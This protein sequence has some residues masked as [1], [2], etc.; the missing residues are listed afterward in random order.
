MRIVLLHG[1]LMSPGIWSAVRRAL[2]PALEVVAPSQP[3]HGTEPPLTDNSMAGW[4]DWL[5]TRADTDKPLLLV[6]HSMGGML[7]M[8]MLAHRPE[9]VAGVVVVAATATAWSAEQ[10]AGWQS[11]LA[12]AAR[13][14]APQMAQALGGV[15]FGARY[16]HDH[17]EEVG[18]W[19][20]LWRDEQDLAAAGRLG[21]VIAQREELTARPLRR[22]PAAMLRGAEDPAITAAEATMTADWLG[23]S[24]ITV[25]EAGHC[26]PLEA[27][28]VVATAVRDVAAR[29]A[30][31]G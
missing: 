31:T 27:A 20:A 22:C 15:L 25:P 19:H 2:P 1:W 18:R 11:M 21:G 28:D 7:A 8:S 5:V 12:A 4:R 29:C 24:V 26:L 13:G 10:Q 23:T 17:P 14:W 3:G 6:G 9:R 16:L 30:A